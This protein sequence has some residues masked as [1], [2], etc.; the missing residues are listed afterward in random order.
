MASTTETNS[1]QEHWVTGPH[2]TN[3]YCRTYAASDSKATLVFLHGFI[4][5][6]G[7]YTHVFPQWQARGINVFTFDQRGFGL[8][9]EDTEH[10]SSDSSYA[11]TSG[12]DQLED[13]EWAV[14]EAKAR[15]GEE[16]PVYVMG[17]S[18]GGGTVLEF[19]TRTKHK[20]AG[21]IASAPLILQTSAAPKIA[22]WVG[23]KVSLIAPYATIPAQVKA[24]ELCKDQKVCEAYLQDPLVKQKGT[25][26]GVSDMLN[27]GEEL[28]K[29]NYESW[30]EDLPLLII[31]GTGDKVTSYRASQRFHDA[32]RAKDKTILLYPDGYH[33]L[34]N[35]PDGVSDKVID[36]CISW[37]EVHLPAASPQLETMARL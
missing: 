37:A 23:G 30:P 31:H 25:L 15:F 20:L 11:K 26:R 17:H 28:L 5:H 33:E 9:A 29:M 6:I 1:Y 24:E 13:T 22:R 18:M 27:R 12:A 7:R 4:E 3:F 14:T 2:S 10:K 16:L 21:I 19:A 34:H 8:T 35:E 36:E 32:V